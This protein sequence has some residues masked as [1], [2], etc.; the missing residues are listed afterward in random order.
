M[1]KVDHVKMAKLL[2]NMR[3]A[4]LELK[5][6]GIQ[7]DVH[8]ALNAGIPPQDIVTALGRGMEEIGERF[9]SRDLFLAEL[10]MAGETMKDALVVLSPHLTM[11]V[12]EATEGTTVSEVVDVGTRGRV[13]L[14]SIVGDMHDIGKDVVSILLTASGVTVYDLGIDVPPEAFVAKAK[15]VDADVVGISALL[16]VTIPACAQVVQA[17]EAERMREDVKIILGG[18]AV[19]KWAVTRWGVDAATND[20]MEGV[21]I[22]MAWLEERR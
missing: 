2:E 11:R 14:G 20:A 15:E 19:R 8:A 12:D 10:V 5:I 4:I 9:A 18:G 1:S 17:F 6:D 13:V 22:I 7:N 16:S 21:R 3:Q